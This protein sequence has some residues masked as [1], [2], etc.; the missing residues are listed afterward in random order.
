MEHT[1]RDDEYMKY[2]MH[3]SV[4]ALTRYAVKH[5]ADG[6]AYSAREQKPKS[7][8]PD[9]GYR[10]FTRQDY[11]PTKREVAYNRKHV[12]LFKVDSV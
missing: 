9:S 4:D 2:R 12:I 5:R 6:I 8:C 7:V 1:A 11:A 10:R 3:I